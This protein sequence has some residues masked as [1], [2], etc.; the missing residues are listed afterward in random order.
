MAKDLVAWSPIVSSKDK[1]TKKE[2]DLEETTIKPGESVTQDALGLDDAG[3]AQLL[4]SG[5]VRSMAY[6]DMPETFQ[7]SPVEFLREEMRKAA[8]GILSDVETS[9]E[10]IAA[11][12][13]VNAAST[14]TALLP[15]GVEPASGPSADATASSGDKGA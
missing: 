8:E 6:P 5:A 1:G 9:E 12:N 2:P 4:E 3:W 11:V 10:N 7:G 13:A 15:E 14:G